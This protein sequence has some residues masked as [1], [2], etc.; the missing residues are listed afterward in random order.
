MHMAVLALC[1]PLT[2]SHGTDAN[3]SDA[4]WPRLL[5]RA[6]SLLRCALLVDFSPAMQQLVDIELTRWH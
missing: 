3:A 6:G 5:V 2:S 1:L 4:R